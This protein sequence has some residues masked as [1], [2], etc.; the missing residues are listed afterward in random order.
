MDERSFGSDPA[1]VASL[2]TA[3]IE[4]FLGKGMLCCAKHF[5]G[6]GSAV[7]DSHDD[8]ITV[9]KAAEEL[10]AVDLVPFKAA[11]EAGVPMIMVG[12]LDL[13]NVT[14]DYTPASLSPVVVQ[15]ILRDQLGYTGIVVTD[16]LSMGAIANYRTAAEA[17]VAALAAG[18]DI[19]LMPEDFPEAYQGVLDAVAAGTLTEERIDESVLR[20]LKAKQ[21]YLGGL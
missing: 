4:G 19:P 18:C 5:P 10:E 13:P 2:A 8:A 7:G 3:E 20:I 1:L 11:I 14:G 6:I 12:H 16:S 15:G 17:A 21:Q 9:E